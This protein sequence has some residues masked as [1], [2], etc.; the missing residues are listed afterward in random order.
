MPVGQLGDVQ[1]VPV[2]DG[3]LVQLVAEADADAL[4]ALESDDGAQPRIGNHLQAV[5]RPLHYAPGEAPHA[6]GRAR[7]HIHFG[8]RGGERQLDIRR[9]GA[10]LR[11][12]EKRPR[13]QA[14]GPERGREG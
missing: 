4:T 9:R 2:D 1:A 14:Q 10:G 6:R 5:R 3:R 11:V 8:R 7:Q 13:I 12:G